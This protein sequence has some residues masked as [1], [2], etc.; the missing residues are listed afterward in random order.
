MTDYHYDPEAPNDQDTYEPVRFTD[1]ID[2]CPNCSKPITDQMDSC[3]YCGDILFRHLKHDTFI[4]RKGPLAK[5]VAALILL[6]II[7]GVLAF[8]IQTIL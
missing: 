5:L 3:P 6:L 1:E 8:I 4:P 7:L 2:S